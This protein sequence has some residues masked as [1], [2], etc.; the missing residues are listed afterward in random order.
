MKPILAALLSL[1]TLTLAGAD[2]TRVLTF[3][4]RYDN[5][6]DG[7]DRWDHRREAVAK[8]IDETADLAGLQEVKPNQ[9]QWLKEKL[10]QFGWVGIGRLPDDKD[11]SVP[12]LF[13]KDRFELQASGTFWLSDQPE[14]PG[15]ASFGNQIPRICTWARLRDTK[16]PAGKDV[17]WVYNAHLDHMSSPAREKGLALV[18]DRMAA[19]E[20]GGGA[21]LMGDFNSTVEDAPYKTLAV[22]EKPAMVSSYAATDTKPD[23]TFHGFKG[24]TSFG[25]IDFIFVEKEFWTV[26]STAILKPTYKGIKDT[27]RHVSDHFP[28]AATVSAK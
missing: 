12:I 17:V 28:V 1:S 6:G 16:A 5:P 7:P 9:R 3:N 4:I 22:R 14:A 27:L 24:E 8:V 20:P 10:P 18:A 26:K 2:E 15:S 13:R 19:R 11:E 21:I 25:A 23:G